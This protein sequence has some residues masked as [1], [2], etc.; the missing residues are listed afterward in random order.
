M[1]VLSKTQVGWIVASLDSGRMI[2]LTPE[3]LAVSAERR[4]TLN[5]VTEL[6]PAEMKIAKEYLTRLL[7]GRAK[8]VKT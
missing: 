1:A 3:D 2:V 4:Q 6:N 7:A 5:L 8:A